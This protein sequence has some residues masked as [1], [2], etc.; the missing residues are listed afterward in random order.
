MN[1]LQEKVVGYIRENQDELI[2][3]LGDLIRIPSVNHGITGDEKPCQE[4]MAKKYQEL[5]L[6]VDLFSPDSVSG[7]IDHPGFLP[8]RDYRERPNVVGT[9]RS[10]CAQSSVMLA[11]HIDV[12]PEGRHDDWLYGPFSGAV[13]NG[14]IYGRGAC[15]DKY[16]VAASYFALKAV[17]ESGIPLS[18]DVC[19]ASV[20]D[21]EKGGG[22]GSLAACLKYPCDEYLYLDGAEQAAIAGVGGSVMN[23]DVTAVDF[24]S[25]AV[26]VFNGIKLLIEHLEGLERQLVSQLTADPLYTN[27]ECAKYPLRLYNVGIG[28]PIG[29]SYN[30][31]RLTYTIY[32]FDNKAELEKKIQFFLDDI[33]S[34]EFKH[35]GLRAEGPVWTTRYFERTSVASDSPV[36]SKY[37]EAY[38][39]AAGKELPI[40]CS[41]LSDYYL[42]NNY[43]GGH[44]LMT[45]LSRPFFEPECPHNVNESNDIDRVVDFAC[46]IAL[47]LLLD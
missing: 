14:K 7:I 45:G 1:S 9:Y 2:G 27:A 20:V 43:G 19:L 24:V 23:I 15:D 47:Y 30:R 4:F 26:P 22:N 17:I 36:V 33:N 42:Y 13:K 35:M 12:V 39:L 38:H 3:F 37:R 32:S 11:G 46:A 41:V 25:T 44:A 5:G 18:K 31:G 28:S 16:A 21:E 29:A 8:G 6:E 40:G 10:N 34:N